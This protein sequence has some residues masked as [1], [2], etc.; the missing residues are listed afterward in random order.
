M[1]VLQSGQI[2]FSDVWLEIN[3]ALDYPSLVR[4][5]HSTAQRLLPTLVRVKIFVECKIKVY[6]MDAFCRGFQN[7]EVY[8]AAIFCV[9]NMFPPFFDIF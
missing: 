4:G 1:N 9:C 2:T 8:S 7:Y 6:F 5:V 3:E